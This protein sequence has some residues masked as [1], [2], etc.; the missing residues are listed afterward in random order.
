MIKCRHLF[1]IV[2]IWFFAVSGYG[3]EI[4]FGGGSNECEDTYLAS[5]DTTNYGTDIILSVKGPAYWV[6]LMEWSDTLNNVIAGNTID[7]AKLN[8][9]YW[10][11]YSGDP[12]SVYKIRS[13]RDWVYDEADWAEYSDGN[14]WGTAG[15]QNTTSDYDATKIDSVDLSGLSQDDTITFNVTEIVSDWSADTSTNRGFIFRMEGGATGDY[16]RVYS[17]N[18][19]TASNRPYLTVWYTEG[20]ATNYKPIRKV[21]LRK[22]KF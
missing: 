21:H 16:A 8:L 7:S 15:A 3:D 1:I 10:D 5:G 20:T 12:I 22:V 14:S 13:E 17:S 19:A 6:I 11:N 4:T 9:V 18:N 2:Y